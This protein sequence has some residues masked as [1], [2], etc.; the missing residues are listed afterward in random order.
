MGSGP[1]ETAVRWSEVHHYQQPKEANSVKEVGMEGIGVGIQ[2]KQ[3]SGDEMAEDAGRGA[4]M[5]GGAL[6]KRT[7]PR[8]GAKEEVS[9]TNT[10]TV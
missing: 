5:N 4:V 9:R 3:A 1:I 10:L 7:G 8:E 6:A 2:E